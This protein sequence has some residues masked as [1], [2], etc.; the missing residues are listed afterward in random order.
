MERFQL[1]RENYFEDNEDYCSDENADLKNTC[2]K[3]RQ[4]FVS[5][6]HWDGL[7]I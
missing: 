2:K 5:I 4:S 6:E 7:S 1:N 3:M